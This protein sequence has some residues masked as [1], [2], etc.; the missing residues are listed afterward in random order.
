MKPQL[1]Q[2]VGGGSVGGKGPWGPGTQTSLFQLST[3]PPTLAG[4]STC[5]WL[6]AHSVSWAARKGEHTF[7]VAPEGGRWWQMG[8]VC[9]TERFVLLREDRKVALLSKISPLGRA[10]PFY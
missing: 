7:D 6:S 10:H 5:S 1:P 2:L 9:N 3:P 8:A 4:R